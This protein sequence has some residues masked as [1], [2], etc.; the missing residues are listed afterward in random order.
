M[1]HISLYLYED[2]T[3]PL[4]PCL[5]KLQLRGSQNYRD[6]TGH[7]EAPLCFTDAKTE[8]PDHTPVNDRASWEERLFW[9]CWGFCTKSW[10]LPSIRSAFG[11][12]NSPLCLQAPEKWSK[13]TTILTGLTWEFNQGIKMPQSWQQGVIRD[14]RAQPL[15]GEAGISHRR[16]E[17]CYTAVHA[18]RNFGFSGQRWNS[19]TDGPAWR[20]Q[21]HFSWFLTAVVKGS[22]SPNNGTC[23][24]P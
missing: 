14:K 13:A 23:D 15:G 7:L 18:L 19:P 8:N 24:L 22:F 12:I 1:N 3:A 11:E 5:C 20:R 9:G 21:P 10:P 4:P 6:L 2:S 16:Q 17:Q